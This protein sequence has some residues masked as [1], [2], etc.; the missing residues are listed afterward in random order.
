MARFLFGWEF[1]SGLG[2]VSPISEFARRLT[3]RGHEVQAITCDPY[4]SYKAF[5]DFSIPCYSLPKPLKPSKK[6]KALTMASV[7]YN[8]GYHSS[9]ALA[10]NLAAWR[11]LIRALSPDVMIVNYAPSG[12]LGARSLNVPVLQFGTGFEVPPL[13]VPIPGLSLNGKLPE[14]KVRTLENGVTGKINRALKRL[15]MPGIQHLKDAFTADRN[16]LVTLP[17]L[18]H[19]RERKGG[20]YIGPLISIPFDT[21]PDWPPGAKGSKRVF[22]YLKAKHEGTKNMLEALSKANAS[23]LAYVSG[24][25]ASDSSSYASDTLHFS[26]QP[27]NLQRACKEAD[28]VVCH[29][30]HGTIAA[31]ILNGARLLL[32][33]E[34]RKGE[35]WIN[36]KNVLRLRAGLLI[37]R[38]DGVATI[39]GALDKLLD[40]S[41]EFDST[42]IVQ[43]YST[44]DHQAPW[45]KVVQAA[46]ELA[47]TL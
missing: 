33:P 8:V 34:S 29:A 42:E 20:E 7:L 10:V 23:A 24:L 15:G 47:G 31:A 5:G 17:E 9:A 19:Y 35:Q 21:P 1:G 11:A 46:E 16:L 12:I 39:G 18:D 37:G 45:E 38:D 44:F 28:V 40:D 2:H 32:L 14:D 25:R 6:I 22:C 3:S 27:V 26:A 36:A 4:A 41:G 13:E 43:K 30:G